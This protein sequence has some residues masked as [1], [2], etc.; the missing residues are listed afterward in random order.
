MSEQS[1]IEAVSRRLALALDALAASVER[2]READREQETLGAQM[3]ALE[4]DRSRLASE[5]DACTAR[6]RA[7]E[8]SNRAAT[9]R[10]DAAMA[11]IRAVLATAER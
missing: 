11:T 3:Q 7:L 9:Q 6:V 1:S 10:L 4:S 2:R 5:L 8:Q